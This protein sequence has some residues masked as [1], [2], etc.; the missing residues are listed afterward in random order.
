MSIR[1]VLE[2]KTGPLI[3]YLNSIARIYFMHAVIWKSPPPAVQL[4]DDEVHVWRASLA[5]D[6]AMVAKLRQLLTPDEC[7]RA[8][9]YYRSRDRRQSIVARGILR[10]IIS[11]YLHFPAAA[12]K[13][14]DNSYGRPALAEEL[15]QVRLDFNLSHSGDLVLYAFTCGRSVGIDIEL[16]REDFA[17]FEI[18][19]QFFSRDEIIALRSMSKELRSVAFFNCWTRKE[20]YIKALGQGLSHPLHC[21]SVSLRPDERVALLGVDDDAREPARWKMHA[22]EPGIG[23]VAALIAGVPL[24]SLKKWDWLAGHNWLEQT[25][26]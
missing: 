8:E 4:R 19:E 2:A 17:T 26:C 6:E 12:L 18:A 9:R 24:F 10:L 23:Y 15:N 16:I 7:K 22:L 5:Q 21:F 11:R 13:F 14:T 25:Q 1:Q 3:W 20:A